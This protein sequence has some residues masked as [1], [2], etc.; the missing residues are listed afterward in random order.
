MKR[1]TKAEETV[2]FILSELAAGRFEIGGRLPAEGKLAELAQTSRLTVRE[3]IQTLAAQRVLNPVQGRGTFVNPVDQWISVEALMRMQNTSPRDVLLQLV[4]VRGFIEIG[5]AEHFAQVITDDQVLQL[6][7]HLDEMVA[8]NAAAD[9]AGVMQADLA[10]HQTIIEGCANPFIAATLEPLGRVLVE[11][12][13]ET[14]RVPLMRAH[15]IVAHGKVLAALERRDRAAARKAMRAHMRET[16]DD[17]RDH[18]TA[19]KA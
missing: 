2:E 10:F 17:I 9:V 5:A 8:A 16:A 12:R 15:A 1:S 19:A 4:E 7:Q 14:S 6:R 3:A 13:L 18:F 11:A